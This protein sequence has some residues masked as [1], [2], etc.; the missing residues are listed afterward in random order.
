MFSK[1][2]QGSLEYLLLIGGAVLVAA[3]VI[4]LVVTSSTTARGPA[5]DNAIL[6]SCL[7]YSNQA[8]CTAATP[9][10][11][12]GTNVADDCVW[13]TGRR[14]CLACGSTGTVAA[15]GTAANPATC[16]NGTLIVTQ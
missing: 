5:Q 12:A 15:I 6:A 8:S 14:K 11:I 2:G 3:I 1:K 7:A 13:D 4:A 16:A 9:G 10:D